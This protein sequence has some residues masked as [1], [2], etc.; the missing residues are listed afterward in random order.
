MPAIGGDLTEIAFSHPTIGQ[1]VF[2]PKANEDN[3]FDTGGFKTNDDANQIDGSGQ[4]IKQLNRTRWIVETTVSSD[5][6]TRKDLEKLSSLAGDPVDA[7]FTISHVNGSVWKGTGAI[8]GDV[9]ANQNT[10]TIKVKFSGGGKLK[11]IAG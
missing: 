10:A 2:F 5:M 3:T 4:M 1:G 7:T 6:K 11:K 9:Q 8:V